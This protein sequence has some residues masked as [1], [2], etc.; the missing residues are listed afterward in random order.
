VRAVRR[1]HGGHRR[2]PGPW[3]L[4]RHQRPAFGQ[5]ICRGRRWKGNGGGESLR[6]PVLCDR[7]Y[8]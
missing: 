6:G 2:R 4:G 7:V 1:L 5:G 3:A 8:A